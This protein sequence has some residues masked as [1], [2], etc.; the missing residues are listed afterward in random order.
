[1]L[2]LAIATDL[3]ATGKLTNPTGDHG[4]AATKLHVLQA[5]AVLHKGYTSRGANW[6]VQ[7]FASR[8]TEL[9]RALH[10]F[11]T[12]Y[13][14]ALTAADF[15]LLWDEQ[16]FDMLTPRCRMAQLATQSA[17]VGYS[18]GFASSMEL[19]SR[20]SHVVSYNISLDYWLDVLE[21]LSRRR[22]RLLVVTGF[23]ASITHQI[24]RLDRIHPK[25]NLSGLSFRVLATPMQF[26]RMSTP[27]WPLGPPGPSSFP[28]ENYLANLE[29]LLA[30]PQWDDTRSGDVALLGCGPIGLPLARHAKERGM[31]A[32][33]VGGVIQLLCVYGRSNHGI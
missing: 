24:P 31:S 12:E 29:R 11:L 33:Y 21:A 17:L 9:P 28:K 14:R 8:L 25:R 16:A 23:A 20:V 13:S 6:N 27:G 1:M 2:W 15:E 30:S 32:I 10:R 4:Q 7:R 19:L 22:A 5:K 18:P 3:I 26:P